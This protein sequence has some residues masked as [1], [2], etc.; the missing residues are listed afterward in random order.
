MEH[1]C[2]DRG[3]RARSVRLPAAAARPRYRRGGGCREAQ[4]SMPGGQQEGRAERKNKGPA[5][6][7]VAADAWQFPLR[8]RK[9]SLSR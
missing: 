7:K 1:R 6:A 3:A 8:R 4:R 5:K 2:P 9:R